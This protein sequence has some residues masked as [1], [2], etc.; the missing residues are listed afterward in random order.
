[1]I[2]ISDRLPLRLSS[3]MNEYFILENRVALK[4]TI[5]KA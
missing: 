5:T 2:H 1:M 4:G 3:P